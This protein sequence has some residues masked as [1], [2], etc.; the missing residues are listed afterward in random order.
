MARVADGELGRVDADGHAAGPGG[1]VVAGEGPLA[2]LVE[3]AV[4]REGQR[5]GGDDLAGEE[6]GA[7]VHG[8]DRT[9]A[10]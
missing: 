8:L 3:L 4:G 6:V 7:E 10:P 9:V 5:M 1:D 2:A